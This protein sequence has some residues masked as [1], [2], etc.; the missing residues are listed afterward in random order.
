METY[1]QLFRDREDK[2]K[3][4]RIRNEPDLA[5]AAETCFCSRKW[6]DD[7]EEEQEVKEKKWETGVKIVSETD[8]E[9]TD[10]KREEKRKMS[11]TY[12]RNGAKFGL[13]KEK[14]KLK[15]RKEKNDAQA[16]RYFSTFSVSFCFFC[17][18]F[19][20]ILPSPSSDIPHAYPARTIY[21]QKTLTGCACI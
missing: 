9:Q 17:F 18:C 13:R 3:T 4:R 20:L 6:H 16:R 7:E 12:N 19:L 15:K 11:S 14:K 8:V 5:V 10:M 21:A 1:V 2:K